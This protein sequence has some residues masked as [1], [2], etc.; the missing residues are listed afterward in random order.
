MCV[1]AVV[2]TYQP[3]L[4]VLEHLLDELIPLVDSVV[5]VDNGSHADLAVW[6]RERQI[7]SVELILLGENKGIA[8]AHNA[9]IQWAR[10][11]RAEFVLL[12]DQDSIPAPDMVFRLLAAMRQIA[13]QGIKVAA[14]GP[15]YLDERNTEHPSFIRV[16]GL[17]VDQRLCRPSEEIVESDILI[18]S[19]SLISLVAL[20]EVGGPLN[21]LFIDQVDLEWCL[22]AKSLGYS[23][24]G[25]RNALLY[26]SLGEA[27][28]RF[29]GRKFLHH[30]PLRHYYIFRNA[31]WLLFRKY[32]PMG[33]KLLIIRMIFIRL[34]VYVCLVSP[35]LTFLTMMTKGIWHGLNK[36]LGKFEMHNVMV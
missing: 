8:A 14:V 17:K 34:L 36:K 9:G 13:N 35:R 2:V 24:F 26:H 30:G 11:H 6:I 20:E 23:L 25:A 1:I 33:W 32:V 3:P 19:G 27:P 15:R 7:E 5:L 28:K 12:M 18:S 22:R 16:S 4:E 21:A 31:V 29:L 10:D